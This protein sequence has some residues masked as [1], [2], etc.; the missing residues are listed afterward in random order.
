MIKEK[1][2]RRAGHAMRLGKKMN[3]YKILAGEP[4]RKRSLGISL[5]NNRMEIRVWRCGPGI[6][7]SGGSLRFN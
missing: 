5:R 7:F 3:A 6:R 1:M 2:I 4:T